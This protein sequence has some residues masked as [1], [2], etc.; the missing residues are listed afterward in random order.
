MD[1]KLF[2][3]IYDELPKFNPLLANGIVRVF[4]KDIEERIAH[5]FHSV[6]HDLPQGLKFV[7]LTTTDP[8]TEYKQSIYGNAFDISQSDIYL[9]K[10]NFEYMG[11]PFKPYYLFLPFVGQG[12]VITLANAKFLIT[13]IMVDKV[14]SVGANSIFINVNK[15]KVNFSYLSHAFVRNDERVV[16]SVIYSDIYNGRGT[17]TAGFERRTSKMKTSLANYLFATQ[18]VVGTFKKYCGIDVVIGRDEINTETYPADEWFICKSTGMSPLGIIGKEYDK[19]NVRLAI[20]IK[21][22]SNKAQGIIASLFYITDFYSYRISDNEDLDDVNLWVLLLALTIKPF[23]PN[24]VQC[25]NSANKHLISLNSYLD[26]ELRTRLFMDGV[27]VESIFDLF[28]EL[29]NT[30]ITRITQ[31]SQNLTTM[32]NKRLVVTSYLIKDIISKIF[33][34]GFKF[35]SRKHETLNPK[36]IEKIMNRHITKFKIANINHGHP[37]VSSASN[38]NDNFIT[39]LTSSVLSQ[40]YVAKTAE[41]REIFTEDLALDMSI[42]EVGNL[43]DIAGDKTGRSRFNM[44]AHI[45]ED[46]VIRRNPEFIELL[47]NAQALIGR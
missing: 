24:E 17:K 32:Y 27:D 38:S 13:P 16:T 44:Y 33:E 35:Q 11:E 39:R 5:A 4:V 15:A 42:A 26:S 21:D 29:I 41:A 43:T 2:D 9:I 40:A 1:S 6:Q 25:L 22:Y 8:Q 28:V 14:L 3:H 31:P 18:G 36:S 23:E 12:G 46:G 34:L 47:D 37:E 10:V 20:K 45:G 19:S 7:G 30:M